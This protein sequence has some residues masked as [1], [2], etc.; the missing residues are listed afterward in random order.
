M[1]F[2]TKQIT[3]EPSNKSV[4]NAGYVKS[5]TLVPSATTGRWFVSLSKTVFPAKPVQS[6]ACYTGTP[7]R[8]ASRWVSGDVDPP[9]RILVK[10]LRSDQGWR[11][12]AHVMRDSTQ[13]WW[14]AVEAAEQDSLQLKLPL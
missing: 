12:L 5:P 13:P 2:A 4:A 3:P 8:T 11:V 1:L 7:A 14:L 6:I 10:L 9:S